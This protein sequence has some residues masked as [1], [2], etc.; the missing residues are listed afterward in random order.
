MPVDE[1][2]GIDIFSLP[3]PAGKQGVF[4][5]IPVK[6]PDDY[7]DGTNKFLDE[8][9]KENDNP[10]SP[11]YYVKSVCVGINAPYATSMLADDFVKMG[12]CDWFLLW[13]DDL[14]STPADFRR[15]LD[16]ANRE[17]YDIISGVVVKKPNPRVDNFVWNPIC[18]NFSGGSLDAPTIDICHRGNGLED[19]DVIT[20]AVKQ[21]DVVGG[22][23]A[24]FSRRA[25]ESLKPEDNGGL[26]YWCYDR[27][28]PAYDLRVFQRL[29]EKGFAAYQDSGVLWGHIGIK[30]VRGH[31]MEE[32]EV[33]YPYT[34]WDLPLYKEV[35]G[36]P[37]RLE[38]TFLPA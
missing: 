28:D 35:P 26:A 27:Q 18:G 13:A 2:K 14:I 38:V 37:D 22:G 7:M 17:K 33:E 20:G 34:F 1:R 12:T 3:I 9:L 19:I 29:K 24:F 5:G 11:Y 10:E 23:C 36:M 4:I 32:T 6:Y 15:L 30:K 25:I 21:F 8:L 16:T 31:Q